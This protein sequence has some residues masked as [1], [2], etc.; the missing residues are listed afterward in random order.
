[1][2]VIEISDQRGKSKGE[3][4][5]VGEEHPLA[6]RLFLLETLLFQHPSQK[7]D[8]DYKSICS[9]LSIPSRLL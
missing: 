8:S 6:V 2:K 5:R 1:M 4:G 3:Q 7:D 9:G